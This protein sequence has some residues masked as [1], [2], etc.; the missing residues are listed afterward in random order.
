MNKLMHLYFILSITIALIMP[1]HYSIVKAVFPFI[2]QKC[3]CYQLIK[4]R[5]GVTL[6]PRYFTNLIKSFVY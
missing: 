5:K 3:P 2:E 4:E 1:Y 6:F